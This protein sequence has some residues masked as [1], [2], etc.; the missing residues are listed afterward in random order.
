LF[1]AK[2]DIIEQPVSSWAWDA[3]YAASFWQ[4]RTMEIGQSTSCPGSK[5]NTS[6]SGLEEIRARARKQKRVK[7]KRTGERSACHDCREQINSL[8]RHTSEELPAI[9]CKTSALMS[10]WTC[11]ES[12]F[13]GKGH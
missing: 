9:E 10:I 1:T 12:L 3:A 13:H 4:G 5:T 8:K 7:L 11:F 2:S 6:A